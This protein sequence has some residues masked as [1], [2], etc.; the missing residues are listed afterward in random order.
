M[1]ALDFPS[2]P[3]RLSK[4]A[5]HLHVRCVC[6]NKW[7]LL[8]PEEWVRQ[9]AL[10]F[11]NKELGFPLSLINVERRIDFNGVQRRYDIC[12]FEPSGRVHV[13]VECK[14]PSVPVTQDVFDQIA[15]YNLS[16]HAGYLMV[17][18]GLKHYYCTMDYQAQRYDFVRRLPSY[19]ASISNS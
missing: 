10:W 3:L 14:A 6:R 5:G 18:N 4:I 13:L 8:T 9:H 12:V 2:Y 11:L 15:R 16:A 1:L 17:T 19:S 7:L